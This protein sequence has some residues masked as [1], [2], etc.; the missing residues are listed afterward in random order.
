MKKIKLSIA[1]TDDDGTTR[2]ETRNVD[3]DVP[4]DSA[5]E[6]R[7]ANN[8]FA[9]L[10]VDV[11][12]QAS[13]KHYAT[14]RGWLNFP[15]ESISMGDYFSAQNSQA[16]WLELCNLVLGVEADLAV[17]LAFKNLEPPSEPSFDDDAALN[18][19]HYIHDRKMGLLNQAVHGLIKAQYLVNRLVHESLGGNLVD[20]SDSDW[21]KDALNRENVKKGLKKKLAEGAISQ[22]E[23]ETICNALDIP[24]QHPKADIALSYRNR[25]AHH[26]RPSVDYAFFFSALES[27]DGEELKDASGKVIGRKHTILARPPLQYIFRELHVAFSEYLGAVV[28]MLQKLNQIEVL[29]QYGRKATAAG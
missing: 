25:L 11:G 3:T 18:D 24:K 13:P 29:R 16:M 21:E 27:R 10:R 12:E 23:Y 1:F 4:S 15:Q 2:D 6:K 22:T 19:L 7:V 5:G 20:T 28:E 14:A 17:A 26:I 9:E 8:L